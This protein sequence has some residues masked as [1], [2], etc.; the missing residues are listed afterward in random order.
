ME[1]QVGCSI[2]DGICLQQQRGGAA[3]ST[4]GQTAAVKVKIEV[5]LLQKV[6]FNGFCCCLFFIGFYL[7]RIKNNCIATLNTGEQQKGCFCSAFI[8]TRHVFSGIPAWSLTSAPLD[9]ITKPLHTTMSFLNPLIATQPSAPYTN[10]TV[11]LQE[12]SCTHQNI[13]VKIY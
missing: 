10:A 2:P 13:S 12:P 4:A 3:S 1:E 5:F 6:N 9:C 11:G 7:Y 8:T